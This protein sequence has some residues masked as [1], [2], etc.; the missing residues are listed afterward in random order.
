M[1]ASAICIISANLVR[2]KSK[3]TISKKH[4][5]MRIAIIFLILQGLVLSG[6]AQVGFTQEG[7]ASIYSEKFEGRTTASGESYSFRKAT[8]AH[9]TIPFGSLV[10]VTNLSNNLSVVVR[11]NDRGPFSPDRIIDLSR[12]AAEKLGFAN[13]GTA[14]VKIEVI[15]GSAQSQANSQNQIVNSQNTNQVGVSNNPEVKRES[16]VE[17]ELYELKVNLI[18][19]KGFTIQVGSYKEMVNMLRIANDL[20]TS[21]KKETRVQVV[22]ANNEKIYRLFIGSFSSRKEAESFK[23]KAIKLYPDCFIVELK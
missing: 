22:T 15:E 6:F 3:R 5:P 4:K 20:K 10:K 12:S 8:C 18:Q 9:L 23:E 11:V 14:K 17:N 16:Q 7:V 2:R 19:P 21:L 13:A 1:S